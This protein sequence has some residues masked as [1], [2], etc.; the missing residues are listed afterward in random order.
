[1]HQ[2]TPYLQS[3]DGGVN[4]CISPHPRDSG[5]KGGVARR[6]GVVDSPTIGRPRQILPLITPAP[7]HESP[8]L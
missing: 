1:M 7:L 5:G 8:A 3:L 4:L 6:G 2:S